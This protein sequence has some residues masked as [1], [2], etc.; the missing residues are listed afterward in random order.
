MKAKRILPIIVV[1]TSVLG[2]W[3][4]GASAA[5]VTIE[6]EAVVDEVGDPH[7]YLGG[8]ITSG[9]TV[10]G[11]YTYD[12]STAD[13]NPSS[14]GADYRHYQAPCGISLSVG[15]FE[16]RT[17]PGNVDFLIQIIDDYPP[18]DNYLVRSRNNLPLPDGTY[19]GGISWVLED[20][21][22]TALSSDAL[23]ATAPVLDDWGSNELWFGGGI[24]GDAFGVISHVTSAAVIPEPGAIVLLGVGA[25]I[26]VKRK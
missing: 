7:G 5:L 20:P 9:D 3:P 24:R 1:M 17:D 12:T 16:F 15:G 22:G 13:S 25:L 10:T 23:P 18:E 8:R 2:F 26:L 6:I 4:P 19:V 21:S 14:Q 11:S